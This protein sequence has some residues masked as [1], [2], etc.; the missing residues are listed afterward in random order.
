[1]MAAFSVNELRGDADA[2]ARSPH[3][4]LEDAAH[5][6]GLSDRADILLLAPERERRCAGDDLEARNVRQ[7]VD[8]L[9]GQ[10]VAEVLVLLVSAQVGKRQDGNRGFGV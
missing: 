4:A 8:D 2:G 9:L 10:A 6:E 7:H 3:A 1:M 5:T